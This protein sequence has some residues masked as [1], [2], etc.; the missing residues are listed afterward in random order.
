MIESG[1]NIAVSCEPGVN[2][3]ATDRFAL[4]RR[5]IDGRDSLLDFKAK[6][7]GGHDSPLPLRDLYRRSRFGAA[8]AAAASSRR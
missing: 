7:G 3:A 4:R 5:Q 1:F 8:D 2:E 6:V